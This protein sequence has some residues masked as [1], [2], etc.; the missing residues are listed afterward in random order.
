MLEVPLIGNL[1][2]LKNGTHYI[3]IPEVKDI[4]RGCPAS[5][6]ER[7]AVQVA[8]EMGVLKDVESGMTAQ[9]SVSV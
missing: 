6:A 7:P 8:E 5:S 3:D 9:T 2:I 4:E 1:K